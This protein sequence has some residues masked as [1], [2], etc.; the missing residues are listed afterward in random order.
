MTTNE[1]I[2]GRGT[3]G[4][5]AARSRW[6]IP[7]LALTLLAGTSTGYAQNSG[8]GLINAINEPTPDEIYDNGSRPARTQVD[9]RSLEGS[10]AVNEYDLVDLHVNNED[11]GAVLQL[12]SIQSQRNIVSSNSVQASVT[13]DLYGVTFYE[14]LDAI[15]HVNGFG[16]IE[17]GNFIYV[18]TRE[19]LQEFERLSRRKMS[20]IIHL[21]YLNATDAAEFVKH[22]LSDSG[23]ITTNGATQAFSLADGTPSGADTFAN[24]ATIVI[25]DYEENVDEIIGLI[26]ELDTKPV[27]VLV[28]ATILQTALN[29]ANAFGVD[30]AIISDLNFGD[31]IGTGGPLSVVDGLIKGKGQDIGGADVPAAGANERGFGLGS[32]IG[33]VDGPSTLKMGVVSKD[34]SVFLRVLDQVTDVTVVSN[35]KLLTLNRQPARVLVGT[36]VGYLNTVTTDTATT[37]AVEFLDVG[38][39]LA[40]RPFVSKNGLIRLELRPQVSSFSL[41]QVTD[42][43][44][45]TVTIP[46]EDTT[47]MTTNVMLRDGQTAV[48]GGLFT[49]TTTSTRRQVPLLGDIPIIGAAF[50]GSDDETRRSEI[51]F[52]ITPSIV[53]DDMLADAGQMANQYVDNARVGA[54]RSLLP[55]SR[56]RRVGQLLIEARRLADEGD[57]NRALFLIDRA[58]RLSPQSP[59]ARAMR[60]ELT[61]KVER[62]PSRVMMNGIMRREL[63][64]GE[65]PLVDAVNNSV[66]DH[67]EDGQPVEYAE[68]PLEPISFEDS[69]DAIEH[70]SGWLT[71]QIDPADDFGHGDRFEDFDEENL[72]FVEIDP[73]VMDREFADRNT[74]KGTPSDRFETM[75]SVATATPEATLPTDWERWAEDPSGQ[76]QTIHQFAGGQ[77]EPGGFLVIPLPGGGALH[78]EWPISNW[79]WTNTYTEVP[80]GSPAPGME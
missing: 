41:R 13:A 63:L 23:H 76:K 37:Q 35:P 38:T 9:L 58:L 16:Y 20:R 5:A 74:G 8:F 2:T 28:E 75:K 36:R 69:A 4:I 40:V 25:R 61:N 78:V 22:L 11:L 66:L 12:L 77:A 44:G 55:F 39:Q 17:K 27:Q 70:D 7:A 18:Y 59:D 1:R 62:V 80:L 29:E 24:T 42:N 60:T 50:R 6:G 43:S 72:Q 68:V 48:L 51:I 21:D 79:D 15:L 65:L 57:T 19:E 32:N 31:F 53:N 14:A 3:D 71:A 10:V 30:F 67:K 34:V 47:E 49:E 54:R 45:S 33:N 46:D 56:D 52:L 73:K 64:T 26:A